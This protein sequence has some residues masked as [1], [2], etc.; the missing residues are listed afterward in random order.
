MYINPLF[1]GIIIAKEIMMMAP[2]RRVDWIFWWNLKNSNKKRNKKR[3]LKRKMKT[4]G[5]LTL[6]MKSQIKSIK[7]CYSLLKM[8]IIDYFTSTRLRTWRTMKRVTIMNLFN[9]PIL[10]KLLKILIFNNF[11]RQRIKIPQINI[12]QKVSTNTPL[13]R[14]SLIPLWRNSALIKLIISWILKKLQPQTSH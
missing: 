5:N 8:N 12:K 14:F 7:I 11:N 1:M 10:I 4:M 6:I 2:I 9:Q 3:H 13:L